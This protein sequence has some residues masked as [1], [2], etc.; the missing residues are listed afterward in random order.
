M[1]EIYFLSEN[2]K[3]VLFYLIINLILH[4]SLHLFFITFNGKVIML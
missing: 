1:V 4:N 2:F 3:E